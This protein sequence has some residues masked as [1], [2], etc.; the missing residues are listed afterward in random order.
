MDV[1]FQLQD[2]NNNKKK[3]E[4]CTDDIGCCGLFLFGYD[5]EFK[6]CVAGDDSVAGFADEVVIR[7]RELI[8]GFS[9]GQF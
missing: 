3:P 4:A 9:H 2:E 1:S 5:V 8:V 6:A 7:L